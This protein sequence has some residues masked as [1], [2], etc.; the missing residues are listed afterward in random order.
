M[1]SRKIPALWAAILLGSF[2][3]AMVSGTPQYAK[4][5]TV[6]DIERVTGLK[7]VKLVPKTP[8]SDDDL[9][10]SSQD[11]KVILAV[12]FLPASTFAAAKSSKRIAPSRRWRSS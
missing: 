3:A 10:F 2:G 12:S 4:Y 1:H 11:G 5:L 6:A 7:G 9:T 8:D